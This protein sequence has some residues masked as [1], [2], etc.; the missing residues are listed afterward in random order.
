MAKKKKK[1]K[2]DPAHWAINRRRKGD[3]HITGCNDGYCK[4]RKYSQVHHVLPVTSLA[5]GTLKTQISD[6]AHI[7][8]LHNSFAITPWDI[9]APENNIGLPLKRAFMDKRAPDDWDGLPCHLV[10]HPDYT[11]EVCDTLL[12]KVWDPMYEEASECQLTEVNL[13]NALKKQSGDF[14]KL[15]RERGKRPA[16]K[17]TKYSWENRHDMKGTWYRGFSMARSPSPR[18]PPPKMEDFTGSIQ[19][20]LNQ[21]FSKR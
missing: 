12:N 15:L 19:D 18:N 16:E 7:D 10:D 14:K 9:N 1:H 3:D 4:S 8:F 11:Q 20:Y 6:Q 2:P 5:D 17:G 21:I 13:A